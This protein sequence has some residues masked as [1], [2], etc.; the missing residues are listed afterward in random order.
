MTS[1]KNAKK[2]SSI[3]VRVTTQGALMMSL[4]AAMLMISDREK[5]KKPDSA[6]RMNCT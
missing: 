6:Q 3:R 5:F 4:E 1:K 2:C